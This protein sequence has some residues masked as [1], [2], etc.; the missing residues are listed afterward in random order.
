M[1][2]ITTEPTRAEF[3]F[4]PICGTPSECSIPRKLQ[5][6]GRC[7]T[8]R[9]DGRASSGGASRALS[10]LWSVSADGS[11][12]V[13]A[14][15]TANASLAPYQGSLLA[16]LNTTALEVGVEFS[17]SLGVEN[18]LGNADEATVRVIRR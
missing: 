3:P 17:F 16:E 8:L 18:F 15:A 7:G 11:L 10:A 5:A 4:E 14:S 1:V 2:S 6:V 12:S 13:G 9:L